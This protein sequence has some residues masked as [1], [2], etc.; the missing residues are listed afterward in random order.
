[1]SFIFVVCMYIHTYICV[2]VCVFMLLQKTNIFKW[3]EVKKIK[4]KKTS[5]KP[6]RS[7]KRGRKRR[8]F[9]KLLILKHIHYNWQK[10]KIR[11]K[12][13]MGS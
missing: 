9:H 10:L 5:F 11:Y 7:M 4:N 2:R 8:N 12:Y 13:L 1:M 3:K 6:D